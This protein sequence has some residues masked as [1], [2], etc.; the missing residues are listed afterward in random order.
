MEDNEY[1]TLINKLTPVE[2]HGSIYLKRDD[3]FV[4]NGQI[5]G[6]VRGALYLITSNLHKKGFVTA[7]N[8]NSPQIN[9]VGTLATYFNKPVYG[10]TPTGDLG[11]EVKLA[12]SKG[13]IIKQEYPGY[14]VVLTKRAKDFAKRKGYY[15]IP[16]GMDTPLVQDLLINQ[17]RNIPKSVK[18][19]V[20]PVGSGS[21][22]IG[23][24]RGIMKYRPDIKILGVR[25]G[26]DPKKK[27]D[28]YVPGWEEYIDLVD[29]YLPREYSGEPDRPLSYSEPFP[30]DKCW[31]GKVRLDPYYE[32]KT[33]P[34]IEKGDLLW[35]VGIRE[36]VK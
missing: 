24:L 27:L 36:Q 11:N 8:R 31:I 23:V 2:K 17:V 12:E 5:G 6:K 32:A 4:F 25:V 33:I 21:S 15:Y 30:I 34:F 14:E 35:I 7:G 20:I 1:M 22:M 3:K 19:I 13:T 29:S 28:K 16:F 10:F 18:R 9:I 26:A